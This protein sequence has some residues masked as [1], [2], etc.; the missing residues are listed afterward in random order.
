MQMTDARAQSIHHSST[1]LENQDYSQTNIGPES[2]WNGLRHGVPP[3]SVPFPT[4]YMDGRTVVLPL[5][6]NRMAGKA[7]FY[8]AA[9][10]AALGTA[11]P[12]PAPC[13]PLTAA[14]EAAP[15]PF[16]RRPGS[17][18]ISIDRLCRP[19]TPG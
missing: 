16:L 13:H 17:D 14:H 7:Q 15:V 2:N 5:R 18:N 3:S 8:V 6:P 10:N 19:Q 12:W 1:I 9:P 4:G 11:K